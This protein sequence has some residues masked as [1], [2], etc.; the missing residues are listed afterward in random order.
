M[1]HTKTSS[2]WKLTIR[3]KLLATCLALLLLPIALLGTIVYKTAAEENNLLIE[4]NLRNSVQMALELTAFYEEAAKSGALTE[5]QAQEQVKELLIGPLKDGKR[6]IE[7]NVDLGQ[8]GYFFILNDRGDLLAHPLMEGQNIA[9]HHT[10][11]GFYYIKD[12]IA[13]AKDGGDFTNYSWPLP[14]SLEEAPKITY[15]KLSSAWG[16]IIAAGSYYEDYNSGQRH[17]LKTILFTLAGCY[18]GGA[19]ILTLFSLHISRPITGL[20]RQAKQ[21]AAGDLSSY[22]LA[23]KN[24]DEIGDLHASFQIM[25]A[26]LQSLA[27]GMLTSSDSL[28]AASQPL[29]LAAAEA[30]GASA[31]IA[32][33]VQSAAAANESQALS[34]RESSRAM[35][36][37][38]AGIQ[39]IAD[40]SLTVYEA[41]VHTRQQADEGH[42]LLD[43]SIEQIH[44]VS[45]AVVELGAVIQ[46]LE[47]RSNEIG[48]I[49]RLMSEI[50]SQTNLLALNASIEAARAGEHGRGFA[51]VAGEVKKLAERSDA[52][53]AQISSLIEA[54]RSEIAAAVNTVTRSEREVEEGVQAIRDTGEAFTSIL[55]SAHRIVEQAQESSGAA[56]QMSASAQQVSAS[57][58]ELERIAARSNDMAHSISASTEEQTA[59][60][61]EVSA[62][63]ESLKTMSEEMQALARRFKL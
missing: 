45:A 48:E 59:A 2:R 38:A 55:S 31:Q 41:S 23:V 36:E 37:M 63:A 19:V 54:I 14:D 47:D 4:K 9:D 17:I 15:A 26:N 62:S 34:I 57:L 21:L 30:A 24:K 13:K 25:H 29:S 52:S 22:E 44:D 11:D 49:I 32:E 40:T 27:R 61:E 8:R 39:R 56:E 5:Q 6:S 10:K 33:A 43:R 51:V 53:A 42:R 50:S 60:L 20:A 18:V 58:Q 1:S 7:T 28:S 46:Q 35:E 3:K 16:W 12:M